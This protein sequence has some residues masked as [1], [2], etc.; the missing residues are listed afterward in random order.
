MRAIFAARESDHSDFVTKNEIRQLMM[1]HT[2]LPGEEKPNEK[3]TEDEVEAALQALDLNHDGKVSCEGKQ[4]FTPKIKSFSIEK[5][6]LNFRAKK[7][8]LWFFL[9]NLLVLW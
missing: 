7:Q 2:R 8:H 3:V 5:S 4:I 6:D 1:V 9:Q